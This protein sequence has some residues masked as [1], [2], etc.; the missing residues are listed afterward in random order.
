[1]RAC[2]RGVCKCGTDTLELDMATVVP[3]LAGPKRPQDKVALTQ[4]DNVFTAPP[5]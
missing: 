2:I 3:S 4:V 5:W 1:M